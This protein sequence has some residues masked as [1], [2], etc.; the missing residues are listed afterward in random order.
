MTVAAGAGDIRRLITNGP[1][2][3]HQIVAIATCVCLNMLDGFDVL[4]M[5]FTASGVS[6]EWGLNGSQLG[7]LLS[8]GLV[9]MAAGSL[10]LAPRADR[11]GRRTVVM[12]SV[13]IVSLGMLFSGFAPGYVELALLRAATGVGIGG[14]LAGATVLVSEYTS[15]KWRITSSFV[16]TSGYSLGATLGGA[17]AAVLIGRFGWRAAFQFGA[18]ASFA[19]LPVTYLALPESL[20]FLI[21]R[22]PANALGKLNR[23]LTKMRLAPIHVLPALESDQVLRRSA[24]LRRLLTPPLRRSTVLIWTAF[25]FMMAGYYFVFS[26]TPKL[27]TGS[28]LTTQQGI[29]SGVLLSFGGIAGTILFAFVARAIE[30][31]RLTLM[32]LLAAAV[33]MCL[34][35]LAVTMLP[36]VLVIGVALGGMSTSAMAG[37]YALTP[38]LYGTG[39]RTSGMGWGIGIGRFGAIL[40]PLAAGV[41]VDHGWQA[42]E[43]FLLFAGAFLIAAVALIGMKAPAPLG[44]HERGVSGMGAPG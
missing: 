27:L 44:S 4:V 13:L 34:F 31:R 40:A 11:V 22:Q 41:L 29:S 16:Y 28:G 26:W 39:L 36:V 24:S 15:D 2:S 33:L 23:L 7:L 21:T 14:I 38:V 19:M 5:S 17:V 10:L 25:F 1:M 18:V 35:A 6:G 43:L 37:F 3:A 32:C 12:A 8:A 42:M 20:D 9:G 30:I